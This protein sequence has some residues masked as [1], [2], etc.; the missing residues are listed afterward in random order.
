MKLT[1]YRIFG[2]V[3]SRRLGLSL[4]IDL[5]PFKTCTYDC[6]YCQVGR[7]TNKTVECKEFFPVEDIL[8]QLKEKILSTSF[9]VITF[10]GSGE[11]TLYKKLDEL[12]YEIKKLTN[13]KIVLLTNGSLFWNDEVRKRVLDVDIILPTIT[14]VFEETHRLIHRPH[15]KL[16]INQIIDGLIKLRNEYD[17]KIF[18]EF[19]ILKG[20]NDNEKELT[21]VKQT[22][23]KINP[24]KIQINTVVRPPSEKIAVPVSSE[25]LRKVCDFFGNKAEIIAYIPRISST[26]EVKEDKIKA[27]LEMIKRRPVKDI[28][29]SNALGID[30]NEVHSIIKGL[31]IK[32]MISEYEHLGDTYYVSKEGQR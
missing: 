27:I 12:V 11:P 14:T 22:I 29:I 25:D 24:E 10:S 4:G 3:P 5:V 8:S 7:T 31:L 18:L 15:P 32:G 1:N 30:I 16:N 21:A 20:I 13:K 2:P 17:G 9:D 28:D 6:I 26:E 19:F 23:D